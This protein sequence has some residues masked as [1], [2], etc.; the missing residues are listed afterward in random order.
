MRV[1]IAFAAAAA[2]TRCLGAVLPG[3]TARVIFAT[4]RARSTAVTALTRAHAGFGFFTIFT[5]AA[6]HPCALLSVFAAR[7]RH[8]VF[9]HR[10]ILAFL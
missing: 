10:R 3:A 5:T 2:G 8:V 6:R 7:H 9:R 4:G 1:A